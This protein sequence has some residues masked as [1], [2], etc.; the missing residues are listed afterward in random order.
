ML[1][2]LYSCPPKRRS[3]SRATLFYSAFFKGKG[4]ELAFE[5][6]KVCN[7]AQ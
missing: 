3:P 7:P 5:E 4:S 6:Y 1:L 2:N